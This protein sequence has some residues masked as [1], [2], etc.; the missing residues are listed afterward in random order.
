MPSIDVLIPTYNPK[1]EHLTEALRSLQAQTNQDWAAL[2]HDDC[3]PDMDVFAT[4]QPFLSDKRFRFERSPVRL[5]IG[6]NWNACLK[7]TALP[8]IAFLFQDDVWHPTYLERAMAIF[9]GHQTVGI[10]CMDHEYIAEGDIS[11]KPLYEHVRAFRRD[12]VTEGF[13][14]GAALLHWWMEQQL[15][16]NIIGEP[17]FVVL[18]RKE[19]E[20]VGYFLEDMPQFLDAEYWT[21]ILSVTD[22]YILKGTFGSFR[23]HPSGTS[24][25]NERDGHGLSDRLRCIELLLGRLHGDHRKIAVVARSKAVKKMVGNFCRRVGAGKKMSSRDKGWL[26][27]FCLRHPF[28]ILHS[29]VEVVVKRM[30]KCIAQRDVSSVCSAPL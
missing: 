24:A 3:S 6:G 23:I 4:I 27:T 2:I 22:C 14:H 16:P 25:I 11:T 7:K 5:G 8:A 1:P 17:S 29:F 18:Q 28:L 30:G 10:V 12:N 19:T 9:D 15:T 21:R 26:R 13:H 20:R